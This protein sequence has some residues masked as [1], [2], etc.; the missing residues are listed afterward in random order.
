MTGPA[1]AGG[2]ASEVASA[3]LVSVNSLMGNPRVNPKCREF[4]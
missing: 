4:V 2:E 3:A 1:G